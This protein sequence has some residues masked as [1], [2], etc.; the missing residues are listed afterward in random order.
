ML[1]SKS[2]ANQKLNFDFVFFFTVCCSYYQKIG[3]A[4]LKPQLPTHNGSFD[5]S[6]GNRNMD[7]TSKLQAVI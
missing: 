7:A 2:Q 6:R 1:F 3:L 5:A 4:S